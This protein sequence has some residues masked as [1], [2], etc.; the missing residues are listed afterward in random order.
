MESGSTHSP[1]AHNGQLPPVTAPEDRILNF[2]VIKGAAVFAL[3]GR[4]V[5]SAIAAL[6]FPFL[7][8]DPKAV[9]ANQLTDHLMQPSEGWK[10]AL[11]GMWE[12]FDTLWYVHIAQ[13]GYDR[14]D[15]IVFSP[16]YPAL[17][18]FTFLPPLLASLVI[19][20]AASFFF[21]WGFQK[22]V[23]LDY[24]HDVATRGLLL[25]AVWP[26]GFIL[27]AG[28]PES[29]LLCCVVWAVY[30]AR[31]D[32][33][34]AAGLMALLAGGTKAVGVFVFL[35]IAWIMFDQKK[36]K[37]MASSLC[38]GAVPVAMA[39]WIHVAG[40]MTV[41]QAYAQYWSTTIADPWETFL[42]ALNTPAPSI[43]LNM[44]A[45][46]VLLVLMLA[47]NDRPEYAIFV[48]GVTGLFLSVKMDPLFHSMN[49]YVLVMFPAFIAAGRIFQS[50]PRFT[51]L[52]VALS[53]ISMPFFLMYLRWG[54][55]V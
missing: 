44:A 8:L 33:A 15:A 12:R 14:P 2:H 51:L 18:H 46:C 37:L 52:F 26:S 48:L 22:L 34:W 42:R 36:W 29:L 47:V 11:L 31:T 35:P 5:F 38:A 25:Y 9:Y 10:Y 55:G 40:R 17:I 24:S 27:F 53:Q 20:T 23:L 28:Y 30:F 16:V 6:Y 19:S 50:R 3:A 21:A 43:G 54:L 1:S 7:H 41:H 13:F 32:R 4:I 39:V 45:L 49:R